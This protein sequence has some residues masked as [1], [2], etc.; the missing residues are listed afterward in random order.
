MRLNQ[1]LVRSGVAP[2]RRKADEIIQSG[3][4]RIN[5][6]PAELG[7]RVEEPDHITLDNQ[8]IQTKIIHPR[9]IAYNKPPGEVCSHRGQ[10]DDETIFQSLPDE[11]AGFKL[12]GRLDKD[13]QGLVL[14]TNDGDLA[15]RLAHPSQGHLKR[16]R[17][18]TDRPVHEDDIRSLR[19]ETVL[20]GNSTRFAGMREVAPSTYEVILTEGRNRQIRR[21]FQQR[22]YS[23]Q[24][25]ERE[26]I[27]RYE[28]G[29]L[30]VGAW[31]EE[32]VHG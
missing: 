7:A 25:L 26:S 2:A 11:F 13:S 9:L 20:D 22:H 32:V 6:Q 15:Q 23:V 18:R 27:G 8:L 28:L 12:I 24:L 21:S 30:S 17:V 16:Y 31:R 1:W 14:I 19:H 5:D 4:I 3:R 10:G 29:D